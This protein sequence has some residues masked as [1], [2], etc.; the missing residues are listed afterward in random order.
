M[1]NMSTNSWADYDPDMSKFETWDGLELNYRVWDG[2]GR[3]VVLQHGVVADTNANWMSMG[4][5]A[6]LQAAGHRVVSLDAR[7]H[8]RSEKPHDP[9]RYSWSAMARDVRALYDELDLDD[10]AQVGYS[11]GGVISLLVAAADERVAKLAVGGIGSGVLDCGGVDRRV[12][13]PEEIRLAMNGDGAGASRAARQFRVLADAVRADLDAIRAVVTG[14]DDRPISTL[15]DV[16]VP[17]LVLAG[18]EDPFAAEPERLADALPD[19]RC[20]VVPGDHMLAVMNPGFKDAL[21]DF[22]R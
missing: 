13:E 16:T 1:Q 21:V 6:A 22:V 14:L 10:V 17:A 18:S 20:V 19:G 12:V 7:G 8:G 5:V 15:D 11:M 3:T 4:V 2:E 9:A